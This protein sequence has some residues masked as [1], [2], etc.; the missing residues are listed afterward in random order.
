MHGFVN[1]QMFDACFLKVMVASGLCFADDCKSVKSNSQ[2]LETNA[3]SPVAYGTNQP[4]PNVC[5]ELVDTEGYKRRGCSGQ[6]SQ[7]SNFALQMPYTIFGLGPTPNFIDILTATI[8]S[9]GTDNARQQKWTQIVPD[10]QVH[11]SL[12]MLNHH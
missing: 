1:T 10:A 2:P 4:G 11:Q 3:N 9:N 7:S 12:L 5:Y 8:P 6:L